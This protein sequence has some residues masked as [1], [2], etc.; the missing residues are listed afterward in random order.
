MGAA[1]G[2]VLCA[3]V[4]GMSENRMGHARILGRQRLK[5][6]LNRAFEPIVESRRD[7]LHW[8]HRRVKS[9]PQPW[10]SEHDYSGFVLFLFVCFDIRRCLGLGRG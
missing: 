5:S 3:T 6:C 4:A 1:G 2:L 7:G 8:Y 10:S 9:C